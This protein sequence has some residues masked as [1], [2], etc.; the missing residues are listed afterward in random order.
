MAEKEMF[1]CWYSEKM[2]A[3]VERNAMLER[4]Q[5]R[6]LFTDDGNRVTLVTRAKEHGGGWDDMEYIGFYEQPLTEV[7]RRWKEREAQNT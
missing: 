3:M 4:Q 6:P 5:Y 7:E 1:H 2:E